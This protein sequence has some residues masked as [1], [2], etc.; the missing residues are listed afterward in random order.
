MS[1]YTV[2]DIEVGDRLSI[3]IGGTWCSPLE[4]VQRTPGKDI[5]RFEF[6]DVE[7]GSTLR[8]KLG[9]YSVVRKVS[10]EGE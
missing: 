3:K 10:S 7:S 6:K 8:M 4:V 2:A 9:P 5:T 1:D